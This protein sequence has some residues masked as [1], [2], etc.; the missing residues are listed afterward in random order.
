ML[1]VKL[2]ALALTPARAWTPLYPYAETVAAA[3]ERRQLGEELSNSRQ[4]E[5]RVPSLWLK[6]CTPFSA[7]SKATA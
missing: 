1:A 3:N 2:D 6:Y 4:S 7:F 5:V